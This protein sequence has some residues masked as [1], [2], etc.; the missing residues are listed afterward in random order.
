MNGSPSNA[1]L[2]SLK[3]P[4][5]AN[6]SASKRTRTILVARSI[7]SD[8]SESIGGTEAYRPSAATAV[9]L[10]K[11]NGKLPSYAALGSAEDVDIYEKYL[12]DQQG[13]DNRPSPSELRTG[14]GANS[15]S[16]QHLK[17]SMKRK[18][19]SQPGIDSNGN[20]SIHS[21][22]SNG[23]T[24]KST[25][26]TAQSFQMQLE[27]VEGDAKKRREALMA[28]R[29]WLRSLPI[30]ERLAQQ[31]QQNVLKHWQQINQDWERFKARTSKKLD[32]RETDLVMTRASKYREQVE[33]YDALQKAA[34]LS[35]KVGHDMWLVSLR[36]DGTRFVPVGNIFSGL[37]C[38][39][40][41]S[42]RIGPRIRRPLDYHQNAARAIHEIDESDEHNGRMQKSI[43]ILE[44]RSL[45]MLAKKKRRLKKQLQMLL[46]HEV[47]HS[48]SSHLSIETMDLF[49]WASGSRNDMR[50][51]SSIVSTEPLELSLLSQ[52]PEDTSRS[53]GD[54]IMRY[55]SRG[56][57]S[58]RISVV[59]SVASADP[60][61]DE[62]PEET[63][64]VPTLLCLDFY[65]DTQ[66]QQQHCIVFENDGT[67]VLH[68]HWTREAFDGDDNMLTPHLRHAPSPQERAEM[69]HFT[70]TSVSQTQGSVLP[71]DAVEFTFTFISD[72][73]GMFLEKWLLDV[74]PP[75][76]MT[77]PKYGDGSI[78]SSR[79]SSSNQYAEQSS[80]R[81]PRPVSSPVPST[82]PPPSLVAAEVHLHCTAVDNFIPR[83]RHLRQKRQLEHKQTVFMVEQLVEDVIKQVN[84]MPKVEFPDLDATATEFYVL[85]QCD[86]GDVYYSDAGSCG[87]EAFSE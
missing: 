39:I 70:K 73:P 64:R 55:S 60:A 30:H 27:M 35:E 66:Q 13:G 75:A 67:T 21:G 52:V 18:T 45:E 12:A 56:G 46:P 53:G 25:E 61:L 43:S 19:L 82:S 59:D 76:R 47:A 78:D 6:S 37:F 63:G 48:E 24:S 9:D 11:S 79:G 72:C 57:P 77:K 80:V 23:K 87:V 36:D 4:S 3:K 44:K 26:S 86:F 17:A 14:G 71:G 84:P 33:M 65:G 58:F 42:T 2:A 41:E 31:R 22:S 16:P 34:P 7:P 68:F 49:E 40:R 29:K 51:T 1:S 28:R 50:K 15:N 83:Q 32:K 81:S 8:A 74:D 5:T 54:V 20:E 69:A 10:R 85:N 62:V 38:P